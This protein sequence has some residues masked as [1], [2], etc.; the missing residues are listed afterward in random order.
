MN[1][2][3]KDVKAVMCDE[4]LIVVKAFESELR[5]MLSNVERTN[6]Y[7]MPDLELQLREILGEI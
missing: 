2:N 5:Q 4:D 3:L 1:P 7:C 6:H